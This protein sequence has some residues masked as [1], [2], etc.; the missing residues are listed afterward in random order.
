MTKAQIKNPNTTP[1]CHNERKPYALLSVYR[2]TIDQWKKTNQH[3]SLQST[4]TP[5]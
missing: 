5:M 2:L 4:H 1:H 3:A